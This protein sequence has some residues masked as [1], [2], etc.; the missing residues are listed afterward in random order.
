MTRKGI[1]GSFEIFCRILFHKPGFGP[2]FVFAVS[3]HSLPLPSL[4]L[5]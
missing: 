4:F 5:G 3:P 1:F 2:K